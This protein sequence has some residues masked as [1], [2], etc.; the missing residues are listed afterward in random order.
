MCLSAPFIPQFFKDQLAE[1][2]PYWDYVIGN[3]TEAE[4][5]AESQNLGTKDLREI[6]KAMVKLP[7]A[8]T[9]RQRTAIITHGTEPTIVASGKEN[10]EV[11]VNEYPVHSIDP[12]KICDTNGAG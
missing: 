9:K 12:E 7:K 10:G 11:E 2:A 8:N 1:T 3:E 6:A 5:W 4:T